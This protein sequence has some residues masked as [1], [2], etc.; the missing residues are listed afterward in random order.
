MFNCIIVDDDY[1][2]ISVIEKYINQLDEFN[3]I[4][5]FTDPIEAFSEIIKLNPDLIF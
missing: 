5:K 2:S 3:I 4:G 1:G